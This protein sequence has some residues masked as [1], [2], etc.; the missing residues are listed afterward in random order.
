MRQLT[1]RAISALYLVIAFGIT[2]AAV[3]YYAAKDMSM[4]LL[5]PLSVL[6]F[7]L[8]FFNVRLSLV[9]LILSMLL[10]PEIVIGS[11]PKREITLRLDDILLLI[12]TLGWLAR[13]AVLKDVGLLLKNPLN[14]PMVLF[15]LAAVV[16]TTF[17]TMQNTVP[18]LS[19]FF[20][21]LKMIEFFFLF[22]VMVNFVREER[23]V[24]QLLTF[25]LLVC[26]IICFYGMFLVLTGGQ[27]SAPFEG[28]EEKNTLGGYL[29]L[30]GAV[31]GGVALHTDSKNERF[32]LLAML[33]ILFVVLLFSLSR[34]SW[35]ACI[36]GII[37]LFFGARRRSIYLVVILLLISLLPFVLPE[38]V[39]QRASFTF[40]QAIHPA[41][42]ITVGPVR[43]DTSLSAR[44]YS[45]I[46][47]LKKVGTYP[48]FGYGVTG[49]YLLDGQFFRVLIEMGIVGLAAFIWL[50]VRLHRF[51]LIGMRTNLSPR[52]HG[53]AVG[54]Y[55]GF[56]AMIAHA[57]A[58]NTFM[59]V[60]IA[61]PFWCLAGLL[62]ICVL[63]GGPD[64]DWKT[65]HPRSPAQT[66]PALPTRVLG[67]KSIFP[68]DFHSIR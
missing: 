41:G 28:A 52:L 49:F 56:W 16:S 17:G 44:L 59:I 35:V 39:E 54:F 43:L 26:A 68:K 50:L 9:L 40:T 31:A 61:E 19:G 2:I 3:Y 48:L 32:L 65:E 62:V 14:I 55:A 12:M 5:A 42:Q 24:G 37:A 30:L 1:S 22:S 33:G 64:G 47:V 7:L 18:P 15:S 45:Y 34:G 21:V 23:E 67:E 63:Q 58:A 51:L 20:F 57:L 38:V 46:D 4:V 10:S 60:R 25:L 29:V 36:A 66:S 11:T 27:V 8:C 13:M 53:L 6:V